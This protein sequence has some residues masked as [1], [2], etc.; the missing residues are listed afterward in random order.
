MFDQMEEN[1]NLDTYWG[2]APSEEYLDQ[3][4]IILPSLLLLT[5]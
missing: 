5:S 2:F 4:V 1:N 3:E